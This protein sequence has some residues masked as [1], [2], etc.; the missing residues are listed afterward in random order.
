MPTI[1]HL[2]SGTFY[3]PDG[4]TDL[5]STA[6]VDELVLVG[7]RHLMDEG[8]LAVLRQALAPRRM[9]ALLIDDHVPAAERAVVDELLNDGIIPVILT[10]GDPL[11][12]ALTSWLDQDDTSATDSGHRHLERCAGMTLRSRPRRGAPPTS[13]ADIL[14]PAEHVPATPVERTTHRMRLTRRH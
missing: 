12:A 4:L 10:D 3:S 14:D 7:A 13:G 8:R 2:S 9:I 11:V 6:A 5:N 1:V